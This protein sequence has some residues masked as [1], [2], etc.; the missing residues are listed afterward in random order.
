MEKKEITKILM[1]KRKEGMMKEKIRGG[2]RETEGNEKSGG[3]K[4]RGR[5]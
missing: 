3:G 5:E 1:R 2:R 4:G